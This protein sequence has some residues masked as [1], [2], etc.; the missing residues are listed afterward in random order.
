MINKY[1]LLVPCYNAEDYILSFLDNI[2]KMSVKF[3]EIIFYDDC[4]KDE[5]VAILKQN[6]QNVI[7]SKKNNGPGFARNRLVEACS[8]DWFHFHDI[9][10]GLDSSYLEK[11]SGIV[12]TKIDIDV[13]LCN[14]NW[15]KAQTKALLFSWTYS[16]ELINKNA[17][18]Y[19][20]ANPIGGIN[21]L[22]RKSKFLT[23]TG[24]NTKI[25]IWED[26]DVHVRLA[27]NKASF[28]VIEEVLSYSLR[29]P[30]SASENQHLGWVV[31]LNLLSEY[32]ELFNSKTERTEIGIQAQITASNLLLSGNLTKAKQ[33]LQLSEL[34]GIKVP[35]SNSKLWKIF[36]IILPKAF[37]I[38]LRLIQLQIAFRKST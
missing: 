25:R 26:A 27:A 7:I 29:R 3:D 32:F 12:E 9:D 20:I 24:F 31:R 22:Y 8:F 10:D 6:N 14:V 15:Y 19:T 4:S 38:Q 30:S 1:S 2:N 21:G 11:V 28:Y 16:N 37:R 18:S 34:C 13:V 5:T 17:I 23:T 33:A 35:H 36:K